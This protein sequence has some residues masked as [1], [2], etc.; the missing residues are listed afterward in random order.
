[1]ER[2]QYARQIDSVGRVLI[3][4]KL[5]ESLNI[6]TGQML[7]FYLHEDADGKYLCIKYD[8]SKETE[9]ERAIRILKENGITTL[10]F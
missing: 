10:D 7:D 3:P 6:E 1:M 4:A 5:R 2:T 8:D 9:I